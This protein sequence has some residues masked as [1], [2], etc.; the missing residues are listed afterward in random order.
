MHTGTS[1]PDNYALRHSPREL[2][3][4]TR[5]ARAFEPFTRLL[6]QQA[7]LGQGMRVLDVGCG[8]GDVAF[9]ASELVGPRGAVVGVDRAPQ[10]VAWATAS[11]QAR[12]ASGVQFLE[13]DPALVA[14]DEPFDAVVGRLILMYYP[15]PVGAL[16]KLARHVRPGGLVVFQELSLADSRSHPPAPQFDGAVAWIERTLAASGAR[17]RLGRELYSVFRAAGLPEPSLRLDALIGGGGDAIACTLVADVIESLLPAMEKLGIATAEEVGLPTLTER[18]REDVE[19][20]G[21]VV[22]TP[23]LIG[24]WTRT[25]PPSGPSG[26]A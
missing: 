17:M 18:L 4:L 1:A 15:D 10:A 6:F 8:S 7:G 9:L 14:F 16:A 5:Q 24:A 2:E 20:G 13:G 19:A 26:N 21:G 11:A 23:E 22:L 25:R 12:S 3:R